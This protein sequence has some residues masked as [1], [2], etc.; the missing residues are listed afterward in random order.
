M[1]FLAASAALD[2]TSSSEPW[3]SYRQGVS[4]EAL[5]VG[6]QSVGLFLP[7][8]LVFNFVLVEHVWFE[9]C[10]PS[11]RQRKAKLGWIAEDEVRFFEE[12][13]ETFFCKEVK[14][15]QE[16]RGA[17]LLLKV[18]ALA[19]GPEYTEEMFQQ[20]KRLLKRLDEQELWWVIDALRTLHVVGLAR[21]VL[22][23]GENFGLVAYRSSFFAQR[24]T[25]QLRNRVKRAVCGTTSLR[26]R[27][28]H[29]VVYRPDCFN[30]DDLRVAHHRLNRQGSKGRAR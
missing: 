13:A 2:S 19:G 30:H 7:L 23:F 25:P 9:V 1:L 22:S 18:V 28:N 14:H 21:G 11:F 3:F 29:K 6:V 17:E 12:G 15:L 10:S 26:R 27:F 5:I 24:A 8:F 4:L 20:S 16:Q